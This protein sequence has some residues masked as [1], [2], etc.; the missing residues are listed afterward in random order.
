VKPQVENKRVDSLPTDVKKINTEQKA[1]DKK[2]QEI[3]QKNAEEEKKVDDKKP[4]QVKEIEGDGIPKEKASRTSFILAALQSSTISDDEEDDGDDESLVDPNEKFERIR[5]AEAKLSLQSESPVVQIDKTEQAQQ[6]E[7]KPAN[8]EAEVEELEVASPTKPSTY[9]PIPFV[10]PPV[11]PVEKA[12]QE[13]ATMTRDQIKATNND[14]SNQPIESESG[15]IRDPE[16]S[17]TDLDKTLDSGIA[18]DH[19]NTRS[20][21]DDAN[22]SSDDETDDRG[23]QLLGAIL[24]AVEQSVRAISEEKAKRLEKLASE[25]PSQQPDSPVEERIPSEERERANRSREFE[26]SI[27]DPI[28]LDM[29]RDNV[30]AIQSVDPKSIPVNILGPR[31]QEQAGRVDI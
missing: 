21:T 24:P 11:K 22:I 30:I 18:I 19:Q 26:Y 27:E 23:L 6:T 4:E 8:I 5:E 31:E 29:F 3:N 12:I 1:D 17:D 25:P 28:D 2:S 16:S 10:R 7:D 14:S 15:Q 9:E 20:S 13:P